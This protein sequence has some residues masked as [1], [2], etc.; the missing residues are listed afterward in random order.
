MYHSLII[1]G[2]NTWDAWK[3]IPSPRP[4]VEIAEPITNYQTIPGRNGALDLSEALTGHMLYSNRTGSWDFLVMNDYPEYNWVTIRDS[5]ASYIH[6]KK[7]TIIL[8]DDP[9]WYY[10]GRLSFDYQVDDNW[11]TV[12][13]GYDLNPFKHPVYLPDSY[14]D[15][16]VNGPTQVYVTG[17]D[18][19]AVPRF[20]VFTPSQSGLYLIVDGQ[21]YFLKEGTSFIPELVVGPGT[22]PFI[23]YGSGIVTIDYRG[24]R[25]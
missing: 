11:S 9:E 8:E 18:E 19:W 6:G 16:A 17:Y 20:I 3:L 24:G 25:L 14:K 1:S 21:Q 2:K 15:V 5:M 23:F 10:E 13:I 22:H 12:S 7:H 4:Y